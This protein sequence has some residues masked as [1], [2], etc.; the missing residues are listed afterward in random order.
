MDLWK[1]ET[2]Q[3]YM[4]KAQ[5]IIDQY[6]N[7]TVE[8]EADTLNINGINTQGENILAYDRLTER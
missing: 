7:Y 4:E 5:F 8:V 3:R 1:P 6:S 2:K